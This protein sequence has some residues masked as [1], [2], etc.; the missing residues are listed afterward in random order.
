MKVVMISSDPD[1]LRKDSPAARRLEDYRGMVEALFPLVIAGSNNV[2]GFLRA[3]REGA[4]T[5]TRES[6]KNFLIT[7]QDASER[8]FIAWILARRFHVPLELQIHTDILSPWYRRE[9]LKNKVRVMLARFLLPRASHIRVVSERIKRSLIKQ[10][11]ILENKINVLP[12]LILTETRGIKNM[13]SQENYASFTF[14]M[15]SRLT[16]E[17]NIDL[18]LRSFA[19]LVKIHPQTHLVIVGDGPEKQKLE[20]LASR[21][22]IPASRFQFVGWQDNLEQYWQKAD[23]YLL[24]SNYEGYGRT[25]I[26]AL[27]N[28]VPVIMTDVGIAG[29]LVRNEDNGLIV[30]VHDEAALTAAMRRMVEDEVLREK[31]SSNARDITKYLLSKDAY[32]AAMKQNWEEALKKYNKPRVAYIL[33]EYNIDIDTHFLHLYGLIDRAYGKLD[34]QLVIEKGRNKNDL[35]PSATGV[36]IQRYNWIPFR[37][38]ELLLIL[39]RLRLRGIRNFY[40]HYSFFGGLAA[41]TVTKLFGGKAFYWNCG[42]PWLYKKERGWFEERL[43]RFILRNSILVTGTEG[44]AQQYRAHYQLRENRILVMPNWITP[45]LYFENLS[46]RDDIRKRLNLPLNKKI[47]LFVHHL[48]KRKGAHRIVPI[49]QA[50]RDIPHIFFMIVGEGPEKANIEWGI[51]NYELGEVTRMEGSAP[52]HRIPL[53]M[54]AADVFFMPSDEEGFPHVILEAMAVGTP[55]VASD[56][57][58]TREIIPESAKQYLCAPDD[59][60]CFADHIRALLTKSPE[61]SK[62]LRRFVERYDIARAVERFVTLFA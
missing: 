9:S 56:M 60:E 16:K 25:P 2:L 52:A 28:G 15:V 19:S 53:Y 1:I 43:F 45:S 20:T 48:S 58:G 38:F 23:C 61:R 35:F 57:G 46:S 34:I 41:I 7:S 42:M 59:I 50:L 33:P 55:F 26:E 32:L 39:M 22:H 40:T 12:I 37:F 54:Q 14:L 44:M 29:E 21:L 13:P 36:I 31:L 5:L 11:S 6:A 10:L 51:K 17:K 47:V 62:E 30:A 18:A 8:G 3:Y 49:A 24:T 27:T 4:R